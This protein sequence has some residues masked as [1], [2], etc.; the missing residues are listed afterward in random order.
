M[1]EVVL[2]VERLSK[3]YRLGV[4]DKTTFVEDLN[5]W[6]CSLIGKRNSKFDEAQINDRTVKN[7]SSFVWALKDIQFEIKKG[8]VWG[9]LGKNGAGKST[10]LK[11]LSQITSP[12]KGSVKIKGKIASLLEVGTGFHPD[13]TGRENIYLNG[14]ILGMTKAEIRKKF[15][16]IVAFSG[17]DKYIDTP[18]KRYSSGMYVRLAFA[19]AAHLDPDILIVDEVLAVGDMEFQSKCMGKMKD[20]SGQ[21][22]TVIFV[23]HNMTAIRM[24]C[25]KGIYLEHGMMKR[26]GEIDEVIENY[27]SDN[28]PQLHATE[29]QTRITENARLYNTGEGRFISCK[30]VNSQNEKSNQIKFK[31]K[32]F[33]QLEFECEKELEDVC[34]ALFVNNQFGERV[35]TTS[36]NNVFEPVNIK[37]GLT[38]FTIEFDPNILLPG[39]YSLAFSV[40]YFKNGSAI[41]FVDKF[42]PFSVL[43]QAQ[44]VAECYP[45]ETTHGFFHIPVRWK[46]EI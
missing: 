19:V 20:V 46:M 22:K 27:L 17:V 5:R 26:V 23:S 14:A 8:E 44:S 43:K 18:V 9:I 11:I 36:F 42:Y 30:I 13:L 37:R 6:W 34:V 25:Q 35:A 3:L 16:D 4:S 38:L 29:I 40:F 7:E 1:S 32:F 15:D 45:W 41:D 10:L 21:G 12:T 24:L 2:R 33:I 31:E 39:D 28:L